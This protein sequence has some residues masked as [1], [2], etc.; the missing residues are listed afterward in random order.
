M[1]ITLHTLK[2]NYGARTPKKRLGR[3]VGSGLGKTSGKGHKGQKARAG[4]TVARHFEGGQMPLYRRVSKLGFTS[5]KKVLGENRFFLLNLSYLNKFE[6]GQVV[7][8]DLLIES[9]L[10]IP[11]RTKVKL[12]NNGVLNKKVKIT[13]DAASQVAIEK[14]NQAGGSIEVVS[15]P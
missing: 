10:R 6:D 15:Q 5:R 2:P 7:T 12:L 3:G 8:R 11:V 13:V 4:G 14:V 1:T 9:G